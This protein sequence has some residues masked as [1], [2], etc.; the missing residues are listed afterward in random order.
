[1][2]EQSFLA[3]VGES[4]LMLFGI[5]PCGQANVIDEIQLEINIKAVSEYQGLRPLPDYQPSYALRG[6]SGYPVIDSTFSC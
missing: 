1:M 4:D 5:L 6:G 2:K 3:D